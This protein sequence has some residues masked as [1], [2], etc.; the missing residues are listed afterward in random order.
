[1]SQPLI[2][3]V[4]AVVAVLSIFMSVNAESVGPRLCA[5]STND[6]SGLMPA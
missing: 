1:M 4:S 6:A 2:D 5:S 3:H